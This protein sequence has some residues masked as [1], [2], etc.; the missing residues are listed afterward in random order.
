MP[1]ARLNRDVARVPFSRS[2]VW[3]V[4]GHTTAIVAI[5]WL[6]SSCLRVELPLP[7]AKPFTLV[8]AEGRDAP[9][10][11][12]GIDA[13]LITF[14]APPRP[15]ARP[16]PH[17]L[18]EAPAT[19]V[20]PTAPVPAPTA[21]VRATTTRHGERMTYEEFRR[22]HEGVAASPNPSA[23]RPAMSVSRVDLDAIDSVGLTS[24]DSGEAPAAVADGDVL[25][26]V[27]KRELS[28]AFTARADLEWGLAVR[29]RFVLRAD[30]SIDRAELVESSGNR[31]FD[32]AVL[33][34]LRRFRLAR[35]EP[36]L[37]GRVFE[38]TFRT[39][40]PLD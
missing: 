5:A 17:P 40:T 15:M 37:A 39:L 29:V 34:T 25:S 2:F 30:G 36:R 3:S 9:A 13:P 24:A 8:L 1:A 26:E 10:A 23:P 12:G 21:P 35:I 16:R 7:A 11:P 18:V 4:A 28:K 14:L 22:R 38:T 32:Q 31:P 20:R 27:L 19:N 33:D 6:A